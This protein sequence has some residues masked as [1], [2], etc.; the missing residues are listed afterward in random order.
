VT[1]LPIK[2]REYT[3]ED[4]N[5]LFHSWLKTYFDALMDMKQA[6]GMRSD[7]YYQGQHKRIEGLLA[8]GSTLVACNSEDESQIYGWINYED[9]TDGGVILHFVYVKQPFRRVGIAKRLIEIAKYSKREVFYTHKTPFTKD[10]AG[11]V[12]K[13]TFN[14]YLIEVSI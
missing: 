12:G 13:A 5:F 9:L 7:V 14:P 6:Q 10:L 2:I 3:L 4:E 8:R 11:V 1:E